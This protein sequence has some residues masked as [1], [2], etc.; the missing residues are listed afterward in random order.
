MI[1]QEATTNRGAAIGTL[2]LLTTDRPANTS[3]TDLLTITTDSSNHGHQEV[4]TVVHPDPSSPGT[5]GLRATTPIQEGTRLIT[6]QETQGRAAAGPAAGQIL[7][8]EAQGKWKKL[9]RKLMLR[10]AWSKTKAR[11]SAKTKMTLLT[12]SRLLS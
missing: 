4:T 11:I 8:N 9:N 5:Q 3:P 1:R 2:T 6:R 7:A 10:K 12:Q